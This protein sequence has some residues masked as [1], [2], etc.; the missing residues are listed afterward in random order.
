MR[1]DFKR[2]PDSLTDADKSALA[3]YLMKQAKSPAKA[4]YYMVDNYIDAAKLDPDRFHSEA[5]EEVLSYLTNVGW[6][7]DVLGNLQKL[8]LGEA[9]ARAAVRETCRQILTRAKTARADTQGY[10]NMAQS[11][12]ATIPALRS[13]GEVALLDAMENYIMEDEHPYRLG[14]FQLQRDLS[15]EWTDG[16]STWSQ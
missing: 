15:G 6:S 14:E 1:E 2:A 4:A 7:D 5:V 11:L 3:D 13:I 16:S 12:T 9:E 8:G 10:K